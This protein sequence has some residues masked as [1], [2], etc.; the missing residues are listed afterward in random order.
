MLYLA[1]YVPPGS[2]PYPRSI[3]EMPAI[4]RYVRGWGTRQGDDGVIALSDLGP[5]GA[6]WLRCFTAD[7]P[8]YGYVD[9]ST[10]E[11]TIAVL[12]P[13]RNRGIGAGAGDSPAGT[14]AGNLAQ[15]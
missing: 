13:Y 3:L 2:P 1:V 10:P 6:A 8:G 14:C 7:A 5:A 11:L 12:K 4:D 15:L 9:E